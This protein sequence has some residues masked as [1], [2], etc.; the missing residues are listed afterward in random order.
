MPGYVASGYTLEEAIRLGL[1]EIEIQYS[2]KINDVFDSYALGTPHRYYCTQDHVMNIINASVAGRD[3]HESTPLMCSQLPMSDPE[4]YNWI[5][6]D[7]RSAQLVYADY[8]KFKNQFW[9]WYQN[10]KI[11]FQQCTTVE[12]CDAYIDSLLNG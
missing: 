3:L 7:Y 6:H 4:V 9:D 10:K 8:V 11:E 12:A 1:G 2:A 5:I